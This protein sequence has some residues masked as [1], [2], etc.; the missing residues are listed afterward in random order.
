MLH[1]L[2]DNAVTHSP[3][4]GVVTLG[5]AQADGGHVRVWVADTGSG[6]ER[7]VLEHIFERFYRADPSRARSTGGSGLGLT[8][9]KQLVEAQGGRIWAESAPDA[10]STFAF[11]LPA[12]AMPPA[13]A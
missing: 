3:E 13:P 8:I 5:A 6:M 12:A 7:E 9:A 11:E 1:N 2:V 10:G 4:G